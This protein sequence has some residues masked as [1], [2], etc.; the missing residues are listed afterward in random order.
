MKTSIPRLR[1]IRFKDS[2]TL[3]VLRTARVEA[4]TFDKAFAIIKDALASEP[5][6][7]GVAIVAWTAE[8]WTMGK[9][10]NN[11]MLPGILL[12]DLARNVLLGIKIEEWTIDTINGN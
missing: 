10:V 4:D 12:P 6:P 8:G 11:T 3:E 5:G 1:R 2:R 9:V 7:A